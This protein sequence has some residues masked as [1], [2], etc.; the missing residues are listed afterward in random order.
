MH[1]YHRHRLAQHAPPDYGR[2]MATTTAPAT[3]Y[4]TT[5]GPQYGANAGDQHEMQRPGG[6]SPTTAYQ[7]TTNDGAGKDE[8]PL[9]GG[10][11]V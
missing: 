3:S 9:R 2:G 11:G 8:M 6:A 10:A 5:Q 1:H 4:T 7:Y